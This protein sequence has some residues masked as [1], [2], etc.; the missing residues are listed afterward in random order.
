MALMRT[1]DMA[2]FSRPRS[3]D[4]LVGRRRA[5]PLLAGLLAQ[6]E[7]DLGDEVVGRRALLAVDA[8]D[9]LLHL[10]PGREP[11]VDARRVRVAARVEGRRSSSSRPISASRR[12]S[13]RT[14][15]GD[16]EPETYCGTCAHRPALRT[17][18]SPS[19][20]CTIVCSPVG[21]PYAMRSGAIS[22]ASE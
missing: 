5:R 8:V 18:A 17:P 4:R 20:R 13:A 15:G 22:C 14:A 1:T 19:A 6:E 21:P 2:A 16:G 9:D 11:G 12:S 3:A 7:L 10:G